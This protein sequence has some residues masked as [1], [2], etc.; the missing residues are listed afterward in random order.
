MAEME[1]IVWVTGASSGIGK[2]IASEFARECYNVAASARRSTEIEKLNME[3]CKEGFSINSLK[4]DIS[5]MAE[6]QEAY[7]KIEKTGQV[8]C[9]VNNAGV[10]TFK[11][12]E[13]NSFEEIK[14]IVETNLLGALYCIKSVLPDMIKKRSGTII[15]ILSVAA[16][17]VLTG[18]SAY[19]ASKAGLLAYTNVLREEVRKNNIRVINILPGATITPMWPPDVLEKHSEQMMSPAEIAKLVVS[20]YTNKSNM[21]AE[22]II[23][24]PITGDL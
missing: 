9:L 17:Q 14:E 11:F 7:K 12:A 18:S 2:E 10:T 19:S 3:L 24:K 16:E 1:K 21:V 4:C 8:D 23:V 15:N 20:L 22:K 13:E 6:V 5:S